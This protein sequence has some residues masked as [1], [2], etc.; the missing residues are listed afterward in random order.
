MNKDTPVLIEHYNK[1]I[2]KPYEV[3]EVI[4]INGIVGQELKLYRTKFEITEI[5][6]L[7]G[8]LVYIG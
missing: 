4:W 8:E 5:G 7:D 2:N 6:L 1:L 3:G